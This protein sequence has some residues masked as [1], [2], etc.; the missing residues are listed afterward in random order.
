MD[1]TLTAAAA[2]FAALAA[3][4]SPAVAGPVED[5]AAAYKRGDY[6]ESLRIWRPA[7]ENGNAR[8]QHD[9]CTLYHLGQGVPQDFA[10][11]A[12]WC[13]K[14]ADQGDAGAQLSLGL[15]YAMGQGVP[16]NKA[17]GVAWVRKSADQG[18]AEAQDVLGIMYQTGSGVAQDY[19]TAAAWFRKAANQGDATAQYH[20]GILHNSGKGV[21]QDYAVAATWYSRRRRPRLRPRRGSCLRAMYLAG[22]GVRHDEVQAFNW[23]GKAASH[24][25]IRAQTMLGTAYRLGVGGSVGSR[26]GDALVPQSGRSGRRRGGDLYR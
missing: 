8:A 14:A 16:Q 7:A 25:V 17:T 21:P 23:F 5:G 15:M 13:R 6:A 12:H 1:R 19:A 22:N 4:T 18:N 3:L 20:L 2:A 24:G 10:A 9:L 26:Q 11:A